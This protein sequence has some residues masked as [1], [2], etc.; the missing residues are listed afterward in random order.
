ML[1]ENTAE[2]HVKEVDTS[3]RPEAVP[4]H[5]SLP[6]SSYREF[7]LYVVE[8]VRGTDSWEMPHL[9]SSKIT[10]WVSCAIS[11]VNLVRLSK[12]L[13]RCTL[14]VTHRIRELVDEV[15]VGRMRLNHPKTLLDQ[16]AGLG[17]LRMP[18]TLMWCP[19]TARLPS[20]LDQDRRC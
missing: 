8:P 3:F 20:R 10:P 16:T 2:V 19:R 1:R 5:T 17:L 13:Y 6:Q 12:V 11:R 9:M 15:T 7:V 14:T 18:H 4:V